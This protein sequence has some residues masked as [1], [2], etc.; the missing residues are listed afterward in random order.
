MDD[1]KK[2]FVFQKGIFSPPPMVAVVGGLGKM[3]AVFAALFEKSGCHVSIIDKPDFPKTN[4][5]A[6]KDADKS[7]KDKEQSSSHLSSHL[8]QSKKIISQSDIVVLAAP[9]SQMD[10]VIRQYVPHISKG[11]LLL[12]IA[13]VKQ[14]FLEQMIAFAG[15]G[16]EIIGAHPL[17]GPY[18]KIEGQRI[19]LCPVANTAC[20]NASDRNPS[21]G[22][23]TDG[24]FSSENSSNRN[25]TFEKDTD[26]N[27]PYRNSSNGN[28]SSLDGNFSNGDAKK[29]KWFDIIKA[30][31]SHHKLLQ[32]T[33][34][35]KTH[36]ENV[37]LTQS[38]LHAILFSLVGAVG[39]K[40]KTMEQV[41]E[42]TTPLFKIE[43]DLAARLL[44][45]EGS[46]YAD[47]A[48]KNPNTLDAMKSFRE[49]F[50]GFIHCLEQKDSL[51]YQAMIE[52]L[53][54]TFVS[55]EAACENSRK[56][57]ENSPVDLEKD[58]SA[59]IKE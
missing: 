27:A 57:V 17:F 21:D 20:G 10:K 9:L 30:F 59:S 40:K 36:D 49:V 54:P 1:K 26:E 18:P 29:F 7:G 39:K 32:I 42:F 55:L 33:C 50:D 15:D 22:E 51:V 56:W 13:S 47:I 12:D 37:A 24:N 19:V 16:V 58:L 43:S 23:A 2:P 52:E 28:G 48:F 4:E 3:G 11:A 14:I 8:S 31:L 25:A 46:L 45:Q 44:S 38:L 41:L 5:N 34:D 6:D 53:R 35:A